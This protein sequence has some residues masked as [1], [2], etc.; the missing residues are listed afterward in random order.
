MFLDI[1]C[2]NLSCVWVF[3]PNRTFSIEPFAV[4][5]AKNKNK[6]NKDKQNK[7]K[8]RAK[9]IL[10]SWYCGTWCVTQRLHSYN[11]SEAELDQ[12]EITHILRKQHAQIIC[13]KFRTTINYF[14]SLCIAK[15]V[16]FHNAL[17]QHV[18]WRI[19][20]LKERQF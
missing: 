8:Q 6:N 2:S 18:G 1:L 20:F 16:A 12:Y 3:H 7:T 10:S 15:L 14:N 17:I 19:Y 11:R 4:L 5:S 9:T 13:R